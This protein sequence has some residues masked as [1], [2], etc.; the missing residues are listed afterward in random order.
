MWFRHRHHQ[1]QHHHW[2]KQITLHV[3]ILGL[4]FELTHLQ[5]FLDGAAALVTN[6]ENIATPWIRNCRQSHHYYFCYNCNGD[7]NRITCVN[8]EGEKRTTTCHQRKYLASRG[9][10]NS[11][12]L[13]FVCSPTWQSLWFSTNLTVSSFVGMPGYLQQCCQLCCDK[14]I[15]LHCQ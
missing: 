8:C 11:C 1:H 14:N 9:F 4:L 6:R 10:P 12:L 13:W 5:W 2:V 15:L 7:D 3:L